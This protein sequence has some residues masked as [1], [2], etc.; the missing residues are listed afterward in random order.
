MQLRELLLDPEWLRRK[1]VAAGTTAVV[2]DFRRYLLLDNC[3]DVSSGA[4]SLSRNF[5]KAALVVSVC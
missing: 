4:G 3:A 2:A 5:F 1:L